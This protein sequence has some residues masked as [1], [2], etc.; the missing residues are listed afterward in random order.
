MR[1]KKINQRKYFSYRNY[2][3][4]W[5]YLHDFIEKIVAIFHLL[6][7]TRHWGSVQYL[8]DR[9]DKMRTQATMRQS[10]W[11]VIQTISWNKTVYVK[12]QYQLGCGTCFCRRQ[13]CFRLTDL[14]I[15]YIIKRYLTDK[16]VSDLTVQ[17]FRI[18]DN[19]NLWSTTTGIEFFLYH[20]IALL[21][22]N[23]PNR[24]SCW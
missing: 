3:E 12:L 17:N 9:D 10:S 6:K 23:W 13:N 14:T 2:N 20:V 7:H 4:T 15:M 11:N 1:Q 22:I 21:H 19:Y 24:T 18:N 8:S 5:G 16:S